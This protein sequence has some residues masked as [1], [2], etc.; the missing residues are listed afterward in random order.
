[1]EAEMSQWEDWDNNWWDVVKAF[2]IA[3]AYLCLGVLSAWWLIDRLIS[4][5]GR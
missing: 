2:M 5:L 4:K 3:V 1:M